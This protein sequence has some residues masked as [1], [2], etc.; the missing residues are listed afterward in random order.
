[1]NPMLP[2][3]TGTG[4]VLDLGGAGAAPA[5]AGLGGNFNAMIL[6][7]SQTQAGKT[8]LVASQG[9][10]PSEG[11]ESLPPDAAS[12]SQ[13]Q[14]AAQQVAQQNDDASG[15]KQNRDG[16]ET[17]NQLKKFLEADVTAEYLLIQ[18]GDVQSRSSQALS[19]LVTVSDSQAADTRAAVTP[20][21]S[22]SNAA[23][24]D[25]SPLSRAVHELVSAQQAAAGGSVVS[26]G[27]QNARQVTASSESGAVKQ[28]ASA[29]QQ[30]QQQSLNQWTKQVVEPVNPAV[31]G[32]QAASVSEAASAVNGGD[33]AVQATGG[34]P[35]SVAGIPAENIPSV[36][37]AQT[38]N[39]AGE[40]GVSR[41]D[42]AGRQTQQSAPLIA[43][44]QK[45]SVQAQQLAQRAAEA[46]S[47][48]SVMPGQEGIVANA[49]GVTADEQKTDSRQIVGASA[50]S[51]EE[52]G[53]I[54]GLVA[55]SKAASEGQ[56]SPVQAGPAPV[57]D[58]LAKLQ[59][60]ASQLTEQLAEQALSKSASRASGAEAVKA[61][62]FADALSASLA[63]S[64]VARAEKVGAEPH[65]LQMQQGL[66][67]GNPAWGQ[68]VSDRVV[69]LA[70]QNGKVAE[71]RLD[72][73]ELGS[74]NV[75]LE[76]K[77]E[78]VSVV[79]NTPHASVKES[80]EQSL[81]R[82]R[83]MFAEQGLELAD[84]SVE[85]QSSQQ[86]EDSQ[87]R[88]AF[89]S[90]GYGAE[91]ELDAEPEALAGQAAQSIS[92]VDYYA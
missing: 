11:G 8:A 35:A 46:Q 49:A 44:D 62:G 38:A 72:P 82:L 34:V 40:S 90:G 53:L 6:Q 76:I 79:F 23:P 25:Q 51:A 47:G 60:S 22:Q 7:T 33:K 32:A 14:G 59:S 77:N 18:D 84:S 5:T 78:Q 21:T 31:R 81:P 48:R 74:L 1:M 71:I 65:Q 13:V 36:A 29:V 61:E 68:A 89:A 73:P 67:P 9:Q 56:K 87:Q 45:V 17:L 39:V 85:D 24:A 28:E 4:S 10:V 91:G 54:K 27:E 26:D 70:S 50:R 88:E 57:V 58:S 19:G 12:E 64:S 16:S 20:Q 42:V 37:A 63:N 80:L 3:S 43:E 41:S 92:M 86:R 69:W 55:E 30:S 15:E 52:N 66:R 75:K 83:E 2:V